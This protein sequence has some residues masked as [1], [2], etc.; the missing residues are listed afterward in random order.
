MN[1][2]DLKKLPFKEYFKTIESSLG[3]NNNVDELTNFFST[4]P[5][6]ESIPYLIRRKLK[7]LD[8]RFHQIELVY[9][10]YDNRKNVRAICWD[11][12]LFLS[13]LIDFF[14]QPIIH[15]EPYSDTT[16]FAF[17]SANPNIEIIKT[18]FPDWLEKSKD[19]DIFV[20][21]DKKNQKAELNDPMFTFVQFNIVD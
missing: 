3:R 10:I 7:P 15:T 12:T 6:S 18:R 2:D 11:V 1:V 17:K 21:Q 19:K 5:F 16:A 20:Y 9:D 13:Q 14:G 4:Q 8:K